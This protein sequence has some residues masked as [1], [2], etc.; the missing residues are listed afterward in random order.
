M[1]SHFS[2]SE[3]DCP[4]VKHHCKKFCNT[5]QEQQGGNPLLLAKIVGP[6]LLKMVAKQGATQ[7]LVNSSSSGKKKGFLGLF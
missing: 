5:F 7:A 3:L 1:E 6:Q 4:F 2:Q